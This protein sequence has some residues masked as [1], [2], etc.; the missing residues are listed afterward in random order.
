GWE[1]RFS[2]LLVTIDKIRISDNP[3][4]VPT[5]QS[6]TDGVVAEVDGPWAIDLHKGGPLAGKGGTDERAVPVAAIA[7]QNKNGGAAFDTTRRYAFG[8]DTIAATCDAQNVNL[9][10]DGLRDYADMI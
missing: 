10:D 1:M 6:Q 9:D 7:N 3:D 4:K 2:R 5:D 8:F